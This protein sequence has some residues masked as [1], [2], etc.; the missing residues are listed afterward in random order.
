MADEKQKRRPLRRWAKRATRCV[1]WLAIILVFVGATGLWL[2]QQPFSRQLIQQWLSQRVEGAITFESVGLSLSGALTLNDVKYAFDVDES[3][4]QFSAQSV[5]LDDVLFGR[6]YVSLRNVQ[7]TVSGV[8]VWSASRG[9]VAW[10]R[11]GEKGP[12]SITFHQADFDPFELARSLKGSLLTSASPSAAAVA[13]PTMRIELLNSAVR[14]PWKTPDYK[15]DASLY[16][17]EGAK[18]VSLLVDISP[19]E[20]AS[21]NRAVVSVDIEPETTKLNA[22]HLH[23]NAFSFLMGNPFRLESVLTSALEVKPLE[24]GEYQQKGTLDARALFFENASFSSLTT[25]SATAAFESM[26]SASYAV[27]TITASL[28]HAPIQIGFATADSIVLPTGQAIMSVTGAG[29]PTPNLSLNWNLGALGEAKISSREWPP[30]ATGRYSVSLSVPTKP[31]DDIRTYL[32]DWIDEWVPHV[33]GGLSIRGEMTLD[34]QAVAQFDLQSE[35]NDARYETAGASFSARCLRGP[36]RMDDKQITAVIA[37]AGRMEYPLSSTQVIRLDLNPKTMEYRYDRKKSDWRFSAPAFDAP[38][39]KQLSIKAMTGGAWTASARMDIAEALPMLQPMLAPDAARVVEGT[40]EMVLSASGDAKKMYVRATCPDLALFSFDGEPAIGLQLRD[41]DLRFEW[42]D[43]PQGGRIDVWI[44][45]ST[46]YFSYAGNDI[47]WP[48]EPIAI[49]WNKPLID[50]DEW[51]LTVSPPGGGAAR[52]THF[53]DGTCHA[54]AESLRLTAFI[55][56]LLNQFVFIED[57]GEPPMV[58][59]AGRLDGEWRI[60]SLNPLVLSGMLSLQESTIALDINPAVLVVG[61]SI[62]TPVVYPID[63]SLLPRNEILFEAARV[64]VDEA[65]FQQVSAYIPITASRIT[66]LDSVVMPL[67]GGRTA[68]N[69][70]QIYDWQTSTPLISGGIQF[71][72]LQLKQANKAFPF[73]PSR[74]R[75]NGQLNSIRLS[76]EALQATGTL[77]ADVFGGT[78]TMNGFALD[79]TLLNSPLW[80]MDV[81]FNKL[82]L[83]E[84]TDY[85]DYGKMTGR[86]SGSLADFEMLLPQQEGQWPYPRRFDIL[87]QDDMKGMGMA[88]RETLQKIINLG[89]TS[90]LQKLVADRDVY[91]FSDLGLRATLEGNDLRLYGTLRNNLFLQTNELNVA[92]RRFFNP[93]EWFAIP[94][95][96]NLAKPEDIIPFDRVWQRLMSQ[97]EG[98]SAP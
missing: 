71:D 65:S 98:E 34:N 83:D 29:S 7:T 43:N 92:V 28:N 91:L 48:G 4:Y 40:G 19:R 41:F 95:N 77:I 62:T 93:T 70:V 97:I 27:K 22:F 8:K 17:E 38:P 80:K 23:T 78:M 67:Y 44:N 84:I 59:A 72:N 3:A 12:M 54:F 49:H 63:F 14:L 39:F 74:G 6:T 36:V 60:G 53:V 50:V 56:P 10:P 13:S 20:G 35:L 2:L 75:L 79:Q 11:P 15:W 69:D 61:A 86:I 26:L 45:S 81:S 82:D 96:I 76:G 25:D 9:V 64:N 30:N 73:L 87:I 18:R 42:K 31:V 47:E 85:F 66:L 68:L 90:G 52:L 21:T 24:T 5:Q 88:S 55:T 32:P 16:Q 46:P 33:K 37:G 89:E 94:V 58:S 1:V 51:N 57:E